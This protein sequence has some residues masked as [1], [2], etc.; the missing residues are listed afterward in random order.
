[1]T[2]FAS[3]LEFQTTVRELFPA[4]SQEFEPDEAIDTYHQVVMALTPR[5]ANYLSTESDRKTRAFCA[6]VNDMVSCD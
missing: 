6:V 4:F 1:M 3:P 2:R 5:L